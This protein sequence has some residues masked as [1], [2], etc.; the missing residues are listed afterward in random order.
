MNRF[1]CSGNCQQS[2]RNVSGPTPVAQPSTFIQGLGEHGSFKAASLADTVDLMPLS[3]AT[4]TN[5]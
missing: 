3:D 1:S 4:N 5:P 2:R